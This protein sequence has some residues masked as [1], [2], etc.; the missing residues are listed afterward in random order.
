MY[1]GLNT[2]YTV[3]EQRRRGANTLMMDWGTRKADELGLETWLEATPLGSML[4]DK[5]GF[6]FHHTVDLYPPAELREDNDEW[7]YWE[8]AAKNLRLA[9]MRRPV[10]G[11]WNEGRVDVASFPAHDLVRNVWLE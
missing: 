5:H 2:N 9:V 3:A 10:N 11:V 8:E 6:G 7:R 4:Y 1:P